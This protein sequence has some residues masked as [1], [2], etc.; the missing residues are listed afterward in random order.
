MGF[1]EKVLPGYK[2]YRQREDSRNTDKLLREMLSG[3]L[4]E[5][6]AHYDDT[7]AEIANRGNL[8]LLNPAEKVTQTLARVIDRL[9][10]ANYGFSG[11]WFGKDK[12][13]VERLEKVHTFDRQLAEGVEQIVG[14]IKALEL[15]DEDGQINAAL[16]ALA[17]KIRDMD[18]ALN[19]REQILRTVG[20][21]SAM[22]E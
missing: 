8:D 5:S 3:K 20:G 6:R 16:G 11:K 18:E 10:Y 12:I 1:L 7:K 22:G 19:Q 14:D 2:G 13:D 21:E 17:H 15:L 4:R 9:R